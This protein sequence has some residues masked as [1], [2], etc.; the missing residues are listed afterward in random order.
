MQLSVI[1]YNIRS[2][3][4][5]GS[6][7]RTCEGLGVEA[8]YICGYSPYPQQKNDQRLPHLA[9]KT[10]KAIQKTALNAQQHLTWHYNP[11]VEDVI[12][13]LKDRGYTIYCLEQN[14]DATPLKLS[15]TNSPTAI[16]LGNEVDG[17]D[18]KILNKSDKIVEIPMSGKKESFNVVVAGAI[19]IYHL[20]HCR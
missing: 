17:I 11:S 16:I 10:D 5:I 20:L 2:A 6:L 8:L 7:F 15:A 3:H 4:N 18:N 9:R 13:K 1:A 12:E 14:K 19:A